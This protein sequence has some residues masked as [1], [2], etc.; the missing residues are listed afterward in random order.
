MLPRFVL[1]KTLYLAALGG[2][3]LGAADGAYKI[4]NSDYRN[5]FTELGL[6][7]ALGYSTTK[8]GRI[9]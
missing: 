9:S 6:G 7:T 3:I 8:S 2:A 5:S 4:A 1:S